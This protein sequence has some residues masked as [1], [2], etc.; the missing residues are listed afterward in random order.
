MRIAPV[1]GCPITKPGRFAGPCRIT[2]GGGGCKKGERAS[3]FS[4]AYR[5]YDS[6]VEPIA[7]IRYLDG[8]A[9]ALFK[10]F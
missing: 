1:G 2:G 4:F 7:V 8:F 6:T 10:L 9:T 3:K 5:I